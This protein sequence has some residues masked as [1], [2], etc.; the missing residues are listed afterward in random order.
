MS[1]RCLEDDFKTC[2]Q[3]MTSRRLQYIFWRRLQ[4]VFSIKFFIFQDDLKASWRSS[5]H[6]ARCLQGRQ[7]THYVEDYW[8]RLQ[9]MS[10]RPTNVSWESSKPKNENL[11]QS[12]DNTFFSQSNNWVAYKW[13]LQ[14]AQLIDKNLFILFIINLDSRLMQCCF[15]HGYTF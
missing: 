15:S 11:S 8:R 4:D 1:L 7:K 9:D 5:R 3:E 6:F 13:P 10:C 14:Y 12:F 2:L